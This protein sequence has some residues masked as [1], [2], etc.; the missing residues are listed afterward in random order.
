MGNRQARFAEHA[1]QLCTNLQIAATDET[2]RITNTSSYQ[3]AECMKHVQA[4]KK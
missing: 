4:W 2:G 3:D 1:S